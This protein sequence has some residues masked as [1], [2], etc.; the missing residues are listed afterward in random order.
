L[1]ITKSIIQNERVGRATRCQNKINSDVPNHSER[2]INYLFKGIMNRHYCWLFRDKLT[3]LQ[4]FHQSSRP[5]RP[6]PLFPAP[7]PGGEGRLAGGGR[8]TGP[9]G[10]GGPGICGICG[11]SGS[12]GATTSGK[13]IELQS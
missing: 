9:A 4:L 7:F 3:N 1:N 13:S 5:L 11:S 12:S 2:G 6:F 10:T 8:L